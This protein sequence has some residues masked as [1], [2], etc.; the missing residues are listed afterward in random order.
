MELPAKAALVA[1]PKSDGIGLAACLISSL[2]RQRRGTGE[3]DIGQV[4]KAQRVLSV[5]VSTFVLA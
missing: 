4:G 5:Y 1:C 2:H 3:R